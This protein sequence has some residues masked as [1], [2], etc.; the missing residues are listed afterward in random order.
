MAA[1]SQRPGTR[2]RSSP[3]LAASLG[4][5][6]L[7]FP[8]TARADDA[9][10][11]ELAK[12]RFDAGQYDEAAAR[13]KAMLD[14]ASPS[15]DKGGPSGGCRI[16]DRD[17]IER[18][19]ALHAASLLALK[20]GP[21]ADAQIEALLRG[22]PAFQPNP[23]VFPQEV[24]DRFTNVRGRIRA[25]L[26]RILQEKLDKERKARVAAQKAVEAERRWVEDV[27]RL[28][29]EE[30]VVHA[31]SRWIALL[32]FGVGQF[33]NGDRV[34]GTFFLVTE[35]LAAATS[36]VSAEVHTQKTANALALLTTG[37]NSPN[38]EVATLASQELNAELQTLAT[39]NRVAFGAWAAITAIG[40][41]QA[42]IGYVPERVTTRRRTLPKRPPRPSAVPTVSLGPDGATLGVIGRF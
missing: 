6:I 8:A 37:Q 29:G 41:G 35:V 19:R 15:C 39:V 10:E 33:Q 36:I 30:T 34:L 18:A 22:N 42:Q 28:A 7:C 40:I 38:D 5:A 17:L 11:L 4:L 1:R 21:E 9:Q 25:E 32:P 12:T 3:W 31:N 26:D 23:A 13:F 14:P 24:I 27:Q 20:R 16:V 2:P